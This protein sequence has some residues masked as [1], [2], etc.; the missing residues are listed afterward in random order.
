MAMRQA[1][2]AAST[3]YGVED[4]QKF[5]LFGTAAETVL[6]S[7][8]GGATFPITYTIPSA[9]VLTVTDLVTHIKTTATDI[10]VRGWI[11]PAGG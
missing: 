7:M 3:P 6:A 2:L 9:K 1:T 10:I 8:D 11:A 4:F 5:T